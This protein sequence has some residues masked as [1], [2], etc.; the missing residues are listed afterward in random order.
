MLFAQVDVDS[1]AYHA[2]AICGIITAIIICAAIPMVTG[3]KYNRPGLGLIGGVVAGGSAIPLGCLS[4]LPV[5]IVFAVVIVYLEN[6]EYA[7]KR[8]RRKFIDDGDRPRRRRKRRDEL[9]DEEE[10]RKTRR[11]NRPFDDD[12][13]QRR[14]RLFDENDD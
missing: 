2:G 13:P 4:G 12:R 1:K 9:E 5:A 14:R 3:L 10:E 6:L 11:G 8:K 7:P